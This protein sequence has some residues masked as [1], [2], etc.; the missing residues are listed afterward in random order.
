M[1]D[2]EIMSGLENLSE[3]TENY[4]KRIYFLTSKKKQA[5]MSE[6][7][8][9]MNR[10]LSSVTE[11]VQRLAKEG[12]LNYEKYG[13][14]TF[15]PKGEEIAKNIQENFSLMNDL[16]QTL[17]IPE[18]TSIIDACAMEH[19]ISETTMDTI[20][21]FIEFIKDDLE[22]SEMMKKFKARLK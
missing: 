22:A 2:K 17:G 1:M 8:K 4:L 3:T 12:F 16:L 20:S 15:T 14:V 11:A 7:A 13:K 18:D 9:S 10:S 6:I 21:E 5:R 19:D